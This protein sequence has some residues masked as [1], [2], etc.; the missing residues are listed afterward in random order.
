[1]RV[2]P[3]SYRL[4]KTLYAFAI[5]RL[6]K[7]WPGKTS[8]LWLSFSSGYGCMWVLHRMGMKEELKEL[9]E[10]KQLEEIE[11][12][13]EEAGR[14]RTAAANYRKGL[15]EAESEEKKFRERVR[16]L[17][18]LSEGGQDMS[19]SRGYSNWFS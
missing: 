4:Y 15:E 8:M 14:L 3:E 19:K 11:R 16:E 12:M 1:M 7:T 13:L 9:E 17:E 2:P 5:N 10:M 6:F 18:H